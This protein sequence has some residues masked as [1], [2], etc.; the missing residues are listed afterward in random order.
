LEPTA[1]SQSTVGC[2]F[3]P[4]PPHSRVYWFGVAEHFSDA[5]SI[6]LRGAVKNPLLGF[7]LDILPAGQQ[8]RCASCMESSDATI[9]ATLCTFSPRHQS[10]WRLVCASNSLDSPVDNWLKADGTN[11]GCSV[12]G[13]PTSCLHDRSCHEGGCSS[14]TIGRSS[15]H[16]V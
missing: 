16:L 8:P 12:E 1:M 15:V 7:G 10:S 3:P 4:C 9:V 6:L 13:C 11:I 5:C 14:A 2:H